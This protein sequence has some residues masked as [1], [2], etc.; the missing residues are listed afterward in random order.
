MMSLLPLTG[1]S[2]INVKVNSMEKKREI[3]MLLTSQ[4]SGQFEIVRVPDGGREYYVKIIVMPRH[5][6][7]PSKYYKVGSTMLI[8]METDKHVIGDLVMTDIFR[9]DPFLELSGEYHA[10]VKLLSE[11]LSDE[12]EKLALADE[13]VEVLESLVEKL[14]KEVKDLRSQASLF[15]H[16]LNL[17]K[18]PFNPCAPRTPP[19]P[20]PPYTVGDAP[21]PRLGE[22]FMTLLNGE[23]KMG[24]VTSVSPRRGMMSSCTIEFPVE[25]GDK[26][27]RDY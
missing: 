27:P 24:V 10:D 11:A 25:V 8:N 15:K 6:D 7:W 21:F 14:A 3:G 26:A 4:F 13:T 16:I 17:H 18:Q 12:Q 19:A 22:P 2:L 23:P 1:Q 5:A 20:Y 9:A